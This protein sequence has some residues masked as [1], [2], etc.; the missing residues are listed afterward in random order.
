MRRKPFM[1]YIDIKCTR[2][3]RGERKTPGAAILNIYVGAGLQS[4]N[5]YFASQ[6]FS[7]TRCASRNLKL[8]WSEQAT[9]D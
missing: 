9:L 2:P 7:P 4:R 3:P 6:S 8:N 1:F 5:L